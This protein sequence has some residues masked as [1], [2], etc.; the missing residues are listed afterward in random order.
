MLFVSLLFGYEAKV[1]KDKV[2]ITID[3]NLT[4]L[5]PGER[6]RLKPGTI[7]CFKSGEGRVIVTGK[8]YKKQLSKHTKSCKLLPHEGNKQKSTSFAKGILAIFSPTK[9]RSV[10]GISRNTAT[11]ASDTKPIIIHKDTKYLLIE[12]RWGPLPVTLTIVDKDG[13]I[14]ET[15]INDGETTTSFLLPVTIFKDGYRI[16]VRN[17]FG[18]LLVDVPIKKAIRR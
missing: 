16:E 7:I 5:M 1:V 18:D 12:K 15:L 9:E 10:Y 14:V 8:H 3:E 11:I 17:A 4:T 2:T 6:I 13:K